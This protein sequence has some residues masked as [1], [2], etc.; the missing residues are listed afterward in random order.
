MAQSPTGIS[1]ALIDQQVLDFY[2]ATQHLK[3]AASAICKGEEERQQWLDEQCHSPR[4]KIMRRS[5]FARQASTRKITSG[6]RKD[7]QECA[8]YFSNHLHQ[9]ATRNLSRTGG[10]SDWGSLL[11]AKHWSSNACVVRECAGPRMGR[12]SPSVCEPSPPTESRRKHKRSI[13]LAFLN[14][15]NISRR[16]PPP[17]EIVFEN[18]AR[19]LV[20]D[21][22]FNLGMRLASRR[23]RVRLVRSDTKRGAREFF[24]K[25]HWCRPWEPPRLAA[26]I[27]R[28]E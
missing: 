27:S 19:D 9:C 6:Q 22:V 20:L 13:S 25:G 24:A 2:H 4:H 21:A 28:G 10:Q 23:R 7:L 16:R 1:L 18:S 26:V 5:G 3:R 14:Y 12:K 11:R 15:P 17:Y 8:M